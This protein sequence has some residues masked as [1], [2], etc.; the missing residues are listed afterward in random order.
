[1][2]LGFENQN[3]HTASSSPPSKEFE[4]MQQMGV[5]NVSPHKSVY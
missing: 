1:M 3:Q 2:K 4:A 5:E